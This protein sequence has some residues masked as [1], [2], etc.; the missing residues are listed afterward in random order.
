[1][2]Y[3]SADPVALEYHVALMKLAGI[4]GVIVDWYGM[5]NFNDYA[6]NQSTDGS[7]YST[8]PGRPD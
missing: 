3:D 1:M 2:P 6:L 7:I 4:D 8:T 5:D